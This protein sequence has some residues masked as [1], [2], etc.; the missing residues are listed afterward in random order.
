MTKR[1]SLP[2]ESAESEVGPVVET[3]RGRLAKTDWVPLDPATDRG[4]LGLMPLVR[5][6]LGHTVAGGQVTIAQMLA[7][8]FLDRAL[9]GNLGALEAI[10]DRLDGALK[11]G[12]A[13]ARSNPSLPPID[14]ARAERILDALSERPGGPSTC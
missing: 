5:H 7:Q 11:S 2:P 4:A 14:P 9:D 1:A 3:D 8:S 6:R 10:L 13:D 12:A